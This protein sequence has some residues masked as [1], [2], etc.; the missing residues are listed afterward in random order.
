MEP[1]INSSSVFLKRC[2]HFVNGSDVTRC[3]KCPPTSGTSQCD[4]TAICKVVT[5]GVKTFD[6]SELLVSWKVVTVTYV[7]TTVLISILNLKV[8]R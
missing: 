2:D 5:I 6:L 7:L 8:F 4:M 3:Q 1:S